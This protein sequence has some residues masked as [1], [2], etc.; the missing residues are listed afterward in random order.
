MLSCPLAAVTGEVRLRLLCYD[1][2]GAKLTAFQD[3]KPGTRALVTGN[4]VF[5]DDTSTS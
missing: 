5:S 1:R 3:W 2:A 4:I